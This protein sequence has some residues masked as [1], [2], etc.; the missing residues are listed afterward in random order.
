MRRVCVFCRPNGGGRPEHAAAA[1]RVGALIAGRE[2]GLVYGGG[3]VVL[4]VSHLPPRG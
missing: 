2:L 3:N 4:R 1:R